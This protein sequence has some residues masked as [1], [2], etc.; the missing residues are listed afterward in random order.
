M[1]RKTL[2]VLF[3][4]FFHFSQV[5][6]DDLL[7]VLRQLQRVKAQHLQLQNVTRPGKFSDF[8]K[9]AIWQKMGQKLPK[10]DQPKKGK[11]Q[12]SDDLEIEVKDMNSWYTF[13]VEGIGLCCVSIVGCICNLMAIY[14]VV[15]SFA[16]EDLP[17]RI[18][19]K[20]KD[21]KSI[22]IAL[23][24]SDVLFLVAELG[25]FGFPAISEWYNT[26]VY[27]FVLPKV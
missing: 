23:A 3:L 5:L 21:I 12:F 16:S 7:S 27:P 6:S 19:Q 26:Y 9:K 2:I 14:V 10:D 4:T 24:L 22:L 17:D 25:I 11:F 20:N 15:K 1:L 13:I 18:R 8:S